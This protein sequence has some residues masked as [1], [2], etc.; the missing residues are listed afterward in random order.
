MTSEQV[1]ELRRRLRLTQA[2]FAK[3]LNVDVRTAARWESGSTT[4]TGAAEA[5]MIAISTRLDAEPSEADEFIRFVVA[6]LA[7]GGLTYLLL[8]LFEKAG[9]S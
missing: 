3:L 9:S 6:A 2:V 8:K 4:P 7:I 5:V 1:L